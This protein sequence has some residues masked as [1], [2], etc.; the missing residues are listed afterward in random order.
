MLSRLLGTSS[1][2]HILIKEVLPAIVENNIEFIQ[3]MIP[4]VTE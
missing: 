3:V 1:E 4:T 2:S